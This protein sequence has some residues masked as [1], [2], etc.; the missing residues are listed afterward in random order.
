M[1]AAMKKAV[2]L[3]SELTKEERYLLSVAYKNVIGAHRSPWRTISSIEQK[4]EGSERKRQMAKEF[5]EKIESELKNTC[6][7]LLV[8]FIQY[9]IVLCPRFTNLDLA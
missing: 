9:M 3:N 6:H 2:E 5:R 8:R 4:V 1:L 7:D